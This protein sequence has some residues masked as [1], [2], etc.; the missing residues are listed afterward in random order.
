M[1]FAEAHAARNKGFSTQHVIE[2]VMVW[3]TI[4]LIKICILLLLNNA[5][6]GGKKTFL[7][8]TNDLFG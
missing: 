6:E 2:A 4:K 1:F 3:L 5:L 8:Q 7:T